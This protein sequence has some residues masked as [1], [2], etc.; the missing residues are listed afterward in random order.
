MI[1]GLLL[2][3]YIYKKKKGSTKEKKNMLK[4]Q[5]N[6]KKGIICII[7]I[8]VSSL[9]S[10]FTLSSHIKYI[11]NITQ[12]NDYDSRL[13]LHAHSINDLTTTWITHTTWH[14]IILSLKGH[15]PETCMITSSNGGSETKQT[16]TYPIVASYI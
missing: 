9:L 1:G 10:H 3:I 5:K 16:G 11:T 2:Y 15:I 6:K 13:R 4:D 14:C 12:N 8:I 7:G